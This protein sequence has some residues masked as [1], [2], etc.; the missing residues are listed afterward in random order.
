MAEKRDKVWDRIDSLRVETR[1]S[2]EYRIFKIIWIIADYN[3]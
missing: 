3:K 2:L 1:Y